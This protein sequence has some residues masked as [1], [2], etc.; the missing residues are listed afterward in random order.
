LLPTINHQPSTINHQPSSGVA[1]SA[2]EQ[3]APMSWYQA[4]NLVEALLWWLVA[5]AISFKVP[6]ATSQQRWGAILGVVAF[7]AFGITDVIEA[8]HERWI[9]LWLWGF[10]CL[11]GVGI[12]SARYTWLGWSQF[13]WK[14]R[15][16][17]FGLCCLIAVI[18]L[19][20]LQRQVAPGW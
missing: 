20:M 2:T 15:E 14:D 4:F 6:R 12:L 3:A 11:C 5:V 19:V 8:N 1:L 10:K 9:P 13:H 7:F 18:V 16:F 17:L